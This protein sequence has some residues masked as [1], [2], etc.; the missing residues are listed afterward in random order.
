MITLAHFA[1]FRHNQGLKVARRH[2]HWHTTKV[3]KACLDPRIGESGV[4]FLVQPIDD[5]AGCIFGHTDPLPVLASKPG[6]NSDD[7]S[8]PPATLASALAVIT[9]SARTLPA[10]IV[11]NRFGQ[12]AEHHL[13]LPADQV[14]EC[15]RA[16]AICTWSMSNISH[17][18]KQLAADMGHASAAARRHADRARV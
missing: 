13:H 1:R 4:Y 14:G 3:R 2:W 9:A 11:R 6:T 18:L 8:A 7:W 10:L 16:T 15:G 5:F 17:Q 12:R